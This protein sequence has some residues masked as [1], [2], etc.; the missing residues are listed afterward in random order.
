MSDN[1]SSSDRTHQQSFSDAIKTLLA[2]LG[3]SFQT[4]LELLVTELE[5]E[6]ERFKQTLLFCLLVVFGFSFGSI[7]LTIFIVAVL[8]DRGWIMAI[9]GLAFVYLA[10]GMIA[11]IMLRKSFLTRAGLLS[12]TLGELRKDRSEMR[13]SHE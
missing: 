1:D 7:L 10:V 4:R 12:A 3:A 2:V 13:P 11:A 8:W 6:R 5:E 9:G